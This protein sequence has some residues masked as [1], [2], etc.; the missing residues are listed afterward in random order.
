LVRK[1]SSIAYSP[2]QALRRLGLQGTSTAR[3]QCGT[4][5]LKLLKIGARIRVIAS[6]IWISMAR[7]C[8]SAEVFGEVFRN[9]E[10]VALRR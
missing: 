8:P 6:K 10:Q 4:I 1:F 7:G 3:A 9:L 2:L 5:R